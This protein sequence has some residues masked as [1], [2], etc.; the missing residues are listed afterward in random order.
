MHA[1]HTWKETV[2]DKFVFELG[3][4]NRI[5]NINILDVHL[6]RATA[7]PVHRP[8]CTGREFLYRSSTFIWSLEWWIYYRYPLYTIRYIAYIYAWL[9]LAHTTSSNDVQSIRPVKAVRCCVDCWAWNYSW[10]SAKPHHQSYYFTIHTRCIWMNAALR[11]SS[12][13]V[14]TWKT[15]FGSHFGAKYN[16]I[17]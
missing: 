8:I 7:L 14:I 2:L 4:G 6:V 16:C 10:F 3:L 5:I 11:R 15:I 12:C 17:V 13:V 9:R 1:T